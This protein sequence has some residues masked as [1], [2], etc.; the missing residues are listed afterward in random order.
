MVPARGRR[1]LAHPAAVAPARARRRAR[2]TASARAC[3]FRSPRS[4]VAE[5]LGLTDDDPWAPDALVWPL[6]DGGRRQ[7]RRGVVRARWRGTSATSTP[8]TRPSSGA[9]RR[10]AV[11]RAAGRA[12]SRRTPCSGRTLLADWLDGRRD[13]RCAAA[14]LDADLAWQPELWRRAR[15]PGRRAAAA[16]AARRRRS[17]GCATARGVRPAGAALAVRPHPAAGHRGRAARARSATH[18]DVHLWLPHPSDALWDGAGRR[19]RRCRAARRGRQPPAGRPPAARHPRAATSA[20]CS[21]ASP[22][23]PAVDRPPPRCPRRPDTLLGWLQDDLRGNAV[24]PGRAARSPPTTAASRCTPATAP[25][26]QVDVLREVLLGLLAGRPDAR[27]ARHPGDVPRHR[28]LRAADH[29]R[30]RPR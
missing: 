16:R 14:T 29:R 26:R 13:R 11:A 24:A 8:A 6:L 21:A 1:A 20:S 18:R 17:P 27:A 10:Y 25:A 19:C 28:D 9:G 4:L 7:P 15:R 3:E 22:R 5:V 23:S 30:L 12:C 2:A